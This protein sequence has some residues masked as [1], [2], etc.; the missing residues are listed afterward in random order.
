MNDYGQYCII[1]TTSE[2]EIYESGIN[3]NSREYPTYSNINIWHVIN[4][5]FDYLYRLF[6]V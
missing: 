3:D 6:V 2:C 1:D 4:N 5:V